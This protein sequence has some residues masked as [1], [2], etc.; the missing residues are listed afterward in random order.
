[1]GTRP[2]L[3]MK[4]HCLIFNGWVASQNLMPI[5]VEAEHIP[6]HMPDHTHL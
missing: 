5:C 1:M 2:W 6:M 3:E 4:K